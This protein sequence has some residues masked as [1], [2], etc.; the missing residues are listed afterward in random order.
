MYY[1]YVNTHTGISICIHIYF[2]C[3]HEV[4]GVA[5]SA[6][7]RNRLVHASKHDRGQKRSSILKCVTHYY[8]SA[9]TQPFMCKHVLQ[10]A[11]FTSPDG[12]CCCQFQTTVNG[13]QRWVDPPSTQQVN[14][15]TRASLRWRHVCLC[16][17]ETSLTEPSLCVFQVTERLNKQSGKCTVLPQYQLDGEVLKD[18]RTS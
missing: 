17:P 9:N 6:M 10:P 12:A 3:I 14:Y 18:R 15:L 7:C 13:T 8:G 11:A 2:I 5:I 1:N 16:N 4:S